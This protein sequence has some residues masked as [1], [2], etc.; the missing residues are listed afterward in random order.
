MAVDRI[1]PPVNLSTG[2]PAV[3]GDM[4]RVLAPGGH[5]GVSDVP[6]EYHLIIR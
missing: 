2:K 5:I 1:R 3:W 6:V 4:H